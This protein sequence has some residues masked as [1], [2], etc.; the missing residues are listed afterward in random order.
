MDLDNEPQTLGHCHLSE[1]QYAW[2]TV[3]CEIVIVIVK[4]TALPQVTVNSDKYAPELSAYKRICHGLTSRKSA[5]VRVPG[6][7]IRFK[8]IRLERS[9]VQRSNTTR[10]A[11]W[12]D[13]GTNR[14]VL[15]TRGEPE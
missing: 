2:E 8:E 14:G 6:M 4:M 13:M 1:A 10:A 12:L 15:I 9:G 11:A 5:D 3:G 7:K